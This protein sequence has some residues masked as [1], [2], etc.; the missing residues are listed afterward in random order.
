[1]R[2]VALFLAIVFVVGS[3][4]GAQ[5]NCGD[6]CGSANRS[7]PLGVVSAERAALLKDPACPLRLV[8]K[9]PSRGDEMSIPSGIVERNF[10]GLTF[11][12]PFNKVSDHLVLSVALQSDGMYLPV[13]AKGAKDSIAALKVLEDDPKAGVRWSIIVR[14]SSQ[15]VADDRVSLRATWRSLGAG[16][17]FSVTEVRLAPSNFILWC[18]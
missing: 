2:F 16:S 5:S 7:V 14:S 8:L 17:G 18:R 1:M 13:S 6:T 4:V 3:D 9:S 15:S 12:A 11:T 10:L